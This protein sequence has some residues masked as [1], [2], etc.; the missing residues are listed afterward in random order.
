MSADRRGAVPEV[1]MAQTHLDVPAA[2]DALRARIRDHRATSTEQQRAARDRARTQAVIEYLATQPEI[3]C[4]AVY[5]SITP[6]PDTLLLCSQLCQEGVDLLV[7]KLAGHREPTWTFLA[8]AD[9]LAPGVRGIPE[10][11][12]DSP[13]PLTA[14]DLVICSALAATPDG[15]RLGTGGGW[16]D[17]TLGTRRTGVPAWALLNADE[18]LADLPVQDHDVRMDALVTELGVQETQDHA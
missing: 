13:V 6:E 15:R 5:L 11:A 12:H 10:P 9:D 4:V 2:K 3:T 18:I 14:A 1:V 8:D 16:F 17:R 7:P